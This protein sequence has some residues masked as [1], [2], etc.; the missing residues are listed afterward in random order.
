M[1]KYRS[2]KK[3]GKKLLPLLEKR[4]GVKGTYSSGEIRT[5]VYHCNFNPKYLPL[6]YILFLEKKELKVV[7]P[8]EFPELCISNYQNE[9]N[10]ILVKKKYSGYLAILSQAI[11]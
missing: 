2:I 4:Y 1:F 6:G 7:M 11:P 3:Y 9:I 8:R 5:T 10:D